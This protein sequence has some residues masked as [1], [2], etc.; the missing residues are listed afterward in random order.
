[1]IRDYKNIDDYVKTSRLGVEK[2]LD[3]FLVY[4]YQDVNPNAKL[5]QNSYRHHFYE[6]SLDINEGCSFQVDNFNYPLQGNRLTIIAPNRLQTNIAHRDLP[7]ESKGFSIFFERDFLG[8]QFNEGMFTKK[9]LFLR[10]DFS[11][12]F[13]LSNKQLNELVNLFNL[14]NYEQ[15]EYGNKSVET[16][17]NLTKV[18]FEKTKAFD[19]QPEERIIS[20]PI[21]SR[22]LQLCNLS[23]LE[24]HTVKDYASILSVTPKHLT[25][26]VKE[27]TGQTALET[28]HNL[29]IG[30]AK[31]LLTQTNLSV[32]QIALELGFDNPE[33]FNVFFKKLTGETPNQFRQ[34]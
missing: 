18:I 33:Y 27:Q 1:M 31:G 23:F 34:I 24:L 17:R 30:Y 16:I 11:P 13:H 19:K 9:F 22:F 26:I 25:E 4:S 14:I 8:I 3:D 6:L 12:S 7:E 29:K 2:H 21:V 10:P 28:I 32:K 5:T 15:K 20:S